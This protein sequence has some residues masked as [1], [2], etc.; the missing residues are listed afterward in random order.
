V[1]IL[2]FTY[3]I[4][5][6]Y[7]LEGAIQTAE[8]EEIPMPETNSNKLIFWVDDEPEGN[9]KIKASFEEQGIEVV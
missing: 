4:I 5:N 6:K 1:L 3:F 8:L 7:N 2:P 9:T